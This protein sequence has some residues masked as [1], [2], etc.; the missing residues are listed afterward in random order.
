MSLNKNSRADQAE[1]KPVSSRFIILVVLA[2]S[3][4]IAFIFLIFYA[5]S[6]ILGF[7][8]NIFGTDGDSG[9][10]SGYVLGEISDIKE[11]GDNDIIYETHSTNAYEVLM[12]LSESTI[13]TRAIRIIYSVD[14]KTNIYRSTLTKNGDRFRIDS[15][16]RTVIYDGVRLYIKEP[17]YTTV[18]EA[19]FNIYDE[20]GITPLSYIKEHAEQE[21]VFYKNADNPKTITVVISDGAIYNEYEISVENGLVL[22]ERS[23]HNGDVYC[24]V[25]TDKIEIMEHSEPDEALFIIPEN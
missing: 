10:S 25:I 13:Y 16:E 4:L 9:V 15:N 14:A 24:A 6:D 8:S 17:T 23:Y 11:N 21:Y 5:K 18:N 3:L 2:A 20:V 7:F 19:E 12:S 22:T 1:R